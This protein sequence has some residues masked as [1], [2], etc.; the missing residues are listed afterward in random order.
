ML[1]GYNVRGL[2]QSKETINKLNM[3]SE[4]IKDMANTYEEKE[5]QNKSEI[6]IFTKN[7]QRF[8][9]RTIK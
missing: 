3:V 9:N 5:E 8:I 1:P 6:E 4:T 7:R 2:T